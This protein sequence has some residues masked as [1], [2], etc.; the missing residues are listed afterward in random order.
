MKKLAVAAFIAAIGLTL[1]ICSPN[2][3]AQ[4][5]TAGLQ[6]TVKDASG[7]AIAGATIELTSPALIGGARKQQ[8]DGSGNYRF[9][10]L[11]PG[12]YTVVVTAKGFRT[13][14][15]V[16][17]DL[18]VGRLPNLDVKLE[19]GAVTETVEVSSAAAMVDTTQSKVAVTVQREVLDNVPK[20]RSF[21]TLI[22]FAPGARGEPLQSGSTSG[23]GSGYQIDGAGDSE[24]VYLIDGVNTTNIQNGGVGKQ[25]QMEFI[26]EVQ[27]KSSSFEAEFG[28]ALGGVIIVVP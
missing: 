1:P 7:G 28:G 8:T 22:P 11:A 15:Q 26:D 27:I 19:V 3:Y 25:F 18:S 24:N 23:A 16:G 10:S 13:F 12:D 20:G 17:I 6:G 14:R 2:A 9:A 5:T 21:Q 4:E